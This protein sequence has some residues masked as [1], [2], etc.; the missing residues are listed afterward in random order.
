VTQLTCCGSFADMSTH[1]MHLVMLLLLLPVLHYVS[2]HCFLF[3]ACL[4]VTKH[5]MLPA[6][7][8]DVTLLAN[9]VATDA[10]TTLKRPAD[11]TTP[12]FSCSPHTHLRP[13]AVASRCW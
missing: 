3:C 13:P 6:L 8:S 5:R 2:P 1:M 9:S 10:A 11:S 4:P 12:L 7:H